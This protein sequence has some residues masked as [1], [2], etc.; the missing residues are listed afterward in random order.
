MVCC[1]VRGISLGPAHPTRRHGNVLTT[2]LSLRAGLLGTAA[3]T[4]L[5][6]PATGAA[7]APP[8]QQQQQPQTPSPPPQCSN[9]SPCCEPAQP[10]CSE[11]AAGTEAASELEAADGSSG[12]CWSSSGAAAAARDPAVNAGCATAGPARRQL[13]GLI[14]PRQVRQ[15]MH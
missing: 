4:T 3:L 8:T 2:A 12:C 5:P 6:P 15:R 7:G 14:P 9:A 1:R 13:A 11:A 10:G